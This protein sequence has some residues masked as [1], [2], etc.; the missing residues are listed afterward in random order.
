M[1]SG[2]SKSLLIEEEDGLYATGCV[3]SSGYREFNIQD[4][5]YVNDLL[6][7]IMVRI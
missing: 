3:H 5:T 4:G 7:I 6:S 1:K 2:E